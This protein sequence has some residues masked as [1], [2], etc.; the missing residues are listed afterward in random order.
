MYKFFISSRF[1]NILL[2]MTILV[3][4][5]GFQSPTSGLGSAASAAANQPDVAPGYTP[6]T[7]L[8][9]LPEEQPMLW[10]VKAYF[11]ERQMVDELASWASIWEVNHAEGYLVVAV[12]ADEIL[13]LEQAGFLVEID[14][15]LSEQLN[16][17]NLPLPGQISG[18]PGYPCYRTVEETYASAEQIAA[19]YPTL[20]SWIQIGAS[21]EK[22]FGSLPGYD[23]MVLRLTNSEIDIPKP[24]LF[25]MASIH[26]R[27]YTPAELATRYAELL[28]ENYGL[29]ADITWLLDYHEIHLLLQANPDGRK[30]AEGGVWWRKNTNSNYCENPN[31]YGIDLNRN[32]PYLWGCCGGSS[33]NP[34][35][36]TYRGP[37]GNSEPETYAVNNY[38]VEIFPD[39]RDDDPYAP[40]PQDATGVFLDLHSYS[41]LVLW[42]W[43]WTFTSPP[44][45]TAL[46]TLGRK[47]AYFNNYSPYQSR[48]LYITDGTTTDTAYGHLGLAAYTFELGTQFFQSCTYFENTIIPGNM[49]ALIYAAKAARTPYMTPSGPDALDLTLSEQEVERGEPVTLTAVLDDTR[50]NNSQGSEPTQNIAAA[51]VYINVPPWLEDENPQPIAMQPLDGQF[52]S[53][54]ETATVTLDTSDLEAGQHILF[55]RGQDAADNWGAFSAVFLEIFSTDLEH[56]KTASQDQAFPGEVIDYTVSQSLFYFESIPAVQT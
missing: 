13:L 24:K 17:P 1:V 5:T 31:Q 27:E 38:L 39:Q 21:W 4:M 37:F 43:G 18:I 34:C 26:A 46:Q 52:N 47:F 22:I 16:T 50:F 25:I 11:S 9:E 20:A 23:M 2:A 51:E 40:A 3:G 30:H 44:N 14:H 54:V 32:Y 48:N 12:S 19:D 35:Y 55:V 36:D 53:P 15:E 45:G 49:P 8:F 7:A 42:P 29:D 41:Q 56:S 6:F 28:V 33:V 10:V